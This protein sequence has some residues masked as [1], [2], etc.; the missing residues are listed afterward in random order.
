MKNL[1]SILGSFYAYNSS[2]TKLT[3]FEVSEC[4]T[5]YHKQAFND[6]TV[7]LQM[8]FYKGVDYFDLELLDSLAWSLKDKSILEDKLEDAFLVNTMQEK[9]ILDNDLL[10]EY[11]KLRDE[12]FKDED[13]INSYYESVVDYD[14]HQPS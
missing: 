2:E 14:E 5:P 3:F 4:F 1:T 9:I 10:N 13:S 6:L 7:S 12:V 11:Q 8:R